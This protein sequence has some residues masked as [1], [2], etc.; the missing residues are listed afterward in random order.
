MRHQGVYFTDN[1]K[2]CV[3]SP[4]GD[5]SNKQTQFVPIQT[6]HTSVHKPSPSGEVLRYS[7]DVKYPQVSDQTDLSWLPPYITELPV[8]DIKC[9]NALQINL[10]LIE[11]IY[12]PNLFLSVLSQSFLVH[13]SRDCRALL[14][15]VPFH[16][17]FV[18]SYIK[19]KSTKSIAYEYNLWR[20]FHRNDLKQHCGKEKPYISWM[21]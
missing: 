14:L 17:F 19:E 8:W 3:I 2:W 12:V 20:T 10:N 5:G 16:E 11:T 1:Q 9:Y 6:V 15:N 18:V 21:F 13:R 4:F 7:A